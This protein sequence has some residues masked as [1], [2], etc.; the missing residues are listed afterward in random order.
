MF[1]QP[2][3]YGLACNKALMLKPSLS[4]GYETKM[5]LQWHS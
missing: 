1:E 5:R 2:F 3:F 4:V